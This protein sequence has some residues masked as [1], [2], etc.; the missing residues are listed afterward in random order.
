MPWTPL[1]SSKTYRLI[2]RR[3]LIEHYEGQQFLF[4]EYRY[5]YIETNLPPSMSTQE[6]I[7]Q[8]YERCDQENI[9]EQMGSGL[10][11][12]RMPVA[13]FAGNCAWLEIAR[14][15]W[16][17]A[18]WIAFLALPVEVLRWKWKRFR[19]AWVFLAAQV[20]KRGR[21]VIVRLSGSHRFADSLVAAHQKLQ[22]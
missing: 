7:D 16:N 22:T 17:F 4:E 13:E 9:V 21:Q 15:A 2:I 11:A 10:A 6:V 3:Q 14:L 5:R 18:K 8:T 12:W 19:Q 1:G 20:T